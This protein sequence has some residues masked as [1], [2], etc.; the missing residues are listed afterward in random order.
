MPLEDTLSSFSSSRGSQQR[1]MT[2]MDFVMSLTNMSGC[3]LR[4]RVPSSAGGL[5]FCRKKEVILSP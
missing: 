4:S 1:T 2:T 5:R 3:A